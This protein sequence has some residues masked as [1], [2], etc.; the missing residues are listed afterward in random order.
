MGVR[1]PSKPSVA[2]FAAAF[3][4]FSVDSSDVQGALDTACA[5]H[6]FKPLATLYLAAHLLVLASEDQAG[7]DGG[8][9]EVTSETSVGNKLTQYKAMAETGGEVF[10]TRT[11]YGRTF[12]T[13]EK[14]TARHGLSVMVG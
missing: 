11:S 2:D 6:S 10:F 8:S 3:P 4:E 7:P 5:I 9:G 1:R 12:L 13:L 14:R